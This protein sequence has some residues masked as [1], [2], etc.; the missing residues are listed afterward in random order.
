MIIANSCSGGFCYQ[1]KELNI[2]YQY[3]NPFIG[4][5]IFA[6]DWKLLLQN[7]EHFNWFNIKINQDAYPL[8]NEVHYYIIL[9][10]QIKIWFIHYDSEDIIK[11]RWINRTQRLVSFLKNNTNWKDKILFISTPYK[12]D[13]EIDLIDIAKNFPDLKQIIDIYLRE[14]LYRN[15]IPSKNTILFNKRSRKMINFSN[16]VIS[17][18]FDYIKNDYK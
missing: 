7:F 1:N 9:D 4:C 2:H 12:T 16:Y 15:I 13:N 18:F 3:N 17:N 10:N 5:T 11:E 8:N 6:K 14:N